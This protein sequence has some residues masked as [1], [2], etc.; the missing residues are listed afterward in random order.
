MAGTYFVTGGTGFIGRFLV[1]RLL[2]RGG[3]VYLV[4]REQSMGKVEQLR[5]L[6]G[7]DDTQLIAVTGDLA[8]PDR[9][10][11]R[12]HDAESAFTSDVHG[13]ILRIGIS[14]MSL[15]PSSSSRGMSVLMPAFGTTDSTA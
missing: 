10:I 12:R 14:R 9:R 7:V 6:W 1:P 11:E 13:M 5:A 4:V 15:A 2:D 8:E 3:R